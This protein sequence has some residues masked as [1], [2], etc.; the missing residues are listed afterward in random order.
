MIIV[1]GTEQCSQCKVVTSYL[2]S[3]NIEHQYLTVG[4]DVEQDKLEAIVS[5]PVKAVPV[6]VRDGIEQTFIELRKSL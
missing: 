2:N 4:V 6:I 3:R 1:Y 5:R